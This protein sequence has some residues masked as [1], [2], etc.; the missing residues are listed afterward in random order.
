MGEFFRV[1]LDFV[2]QFWPLHVLGPEEGGVITFWGHPWLTV[3][4]G[5]Y[6]A[7][8]FFM[9][10]D[11]LNV[12]EQVVD[13][14]P[15]SVTTKDGCTLAVSG[16]ISYEIADPRKALY[17]VQNFDMSLPTLSLGVM[18]H[19]INGRN[20][21]E[22]GDSDALVGEV[23]AGI[24]GVAESRWGIRI[25]DVWITDLADHKVYRVISGS[26]TIVP[27]EVSR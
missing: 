7:I 22:C 16:A 23:K 9:G 2:R 27:V 18:A 6:F 24:V 12:K 5:I 10:V 8:P 11:R 14:R 17:H 26:D 1:L 25:L 4:P 15:Q 20:R 21:D 19:F 3:G 13:L